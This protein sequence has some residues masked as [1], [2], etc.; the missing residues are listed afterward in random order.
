[1][2]VLQISMKLLL[3][4]VIASFLFSCKKDKNIFEK[5][6][7]VGKWVSEDADSEFSSFEF[8]DDNKFI[9]IRKKTAI[10]RKSSMLNW[11]SDLVGSNI[12]EESTARI[13]DS[14]LSPIHFGTYEIDGDKIILYGFGLVRP[15]EITAEEFS[16]DFSLE[17]ENNTTRYVLKKTKEISTSSKTDLL[18]RSWLLEKVEKDT[19]E[20]TEQEKINYRTSLGSKWYEVLATSV[21]DEHKGKT[22]I[23]SRAGTYLVLTNTIN[24]VALLAEWKW[25]DETESSFYYSWGN[26]SETENWQSQKVYIYDLDNNR[27]NMSD[28]KNYLYIMKAN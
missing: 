21:N 23:F 22:M 27:M 8:T 15:V 24:Q 7:I 6:K 11:K 2:K 9:V 25:I 1:M 12:I 17:E 14:D 4:T 16:F 13:E 19:T 26:W 5:E 28:R 3:I 20:L 10:P 18:C